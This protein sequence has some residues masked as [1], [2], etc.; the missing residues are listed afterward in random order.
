MLHPALVELMARER[1]TERQRVGAK[2]WFGR[3]EYAVADRTASR[4]DG[5]SIRCSPRATP[6]RAIGWFL[7]SVGLRLALPP[8]PPRSVR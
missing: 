5:V 8:T 6:R 7:V 4:S 2:R 3:R 1:I